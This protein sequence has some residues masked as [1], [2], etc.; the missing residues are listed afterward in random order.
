ME[1]KAYNSMDLF[2]KEA[3]EIADAFNTLIQAIV[4]SN[5][6]DEKTKQLIYIALKAVQGDSQALSFH[7]LMAKE[8]GATKPEV[9]DALMVTLTVAGVKGIVTGLPVVMDI[10]KDTSK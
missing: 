4:K 10:Y 9:I 6:L 5:G 7:I 3:P 1:N 2:K 8:K